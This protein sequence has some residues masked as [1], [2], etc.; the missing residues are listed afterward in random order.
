MGRPVTLICPECGKGHLARPQALMIEADM[1]RGCTVL[2]FVC[3]V[4]GVEALWDDFAGRLVKG[5]LLVVTEH[6][7]LAIARAPLLTG[8]DALA[9]D[10]LYDVLLPHQPIKGE[11]VGR[12]RMGGAS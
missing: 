10:P 7:F 9:D 8:I 11:Y 12:H 3:T 6:G 4:C 2:D 1:M 5:E